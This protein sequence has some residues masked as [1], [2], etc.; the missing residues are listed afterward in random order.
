MSKIEINKLTNA[1][2][3]MNGTNLLGRAEEVQLPQI[4]GYTKLTSQQWIFPSLKCM[5]PKMLI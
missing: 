1:N 4:N 2:I 5:L 3:Y